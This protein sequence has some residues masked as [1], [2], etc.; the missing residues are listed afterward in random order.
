MLAYGVEM[1][2]AAV[3]EPDRVLGIEETA[4]MLAMT[5]DYLYRNWTK[6]GLGYK[7]AD[8]HVKFTLSK[9]QRYIRTRAGR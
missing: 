2:R 5:T 9:V 8:G 7:D 6:L 3:A 1:N 4:T